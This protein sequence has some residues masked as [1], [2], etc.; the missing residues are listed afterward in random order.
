MN[1]DAWRKMSHADFVLSRSASSFPLP[2][3]CVNLADDGDVM[4]RERLLLM[5]RKLLRFTTGLSVLAVGCGMVLWGSYGVGRYAGWMHAMLILVLGLVAYHA[6][7]A[8]LYQRIA[9][10]G[11]A[12]SH[13]AFRRF[14]EVPVLMLVAITARAVGKPF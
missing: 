13:V 7:C 2:R 1:A 12:R 6:Y 9:S 14:N 11:N 5:S 3:I 10:G 8:V 4:T